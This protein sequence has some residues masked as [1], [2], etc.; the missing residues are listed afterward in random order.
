[1]ANV[2]YGCTLP[3]LTTGDK[4]TAV[5]DQCGDNITSAVG[6]A[7]FGETAGKN[8]TDGYD[9]TFIGGHSGYYTTSAHNL[10]GVGTGA[11]YKNET[12]INLTASGVNALRNNT[13]G[14][15]N[16][17]SGYLASYNLTTAYQTSS[18]GQAALRNNNGNNTSGFGVEAG[19]NATTSYNSSFF[20]VISGSNVTTQNNVTCLGYNTQVT[21]SNQ[22]QL[23]D[24]YTTS[25]AYGAV[26]NR[27]DARDKTDIRDCSIG[28]DFIM[29]LRPVDYKWNYRDAYVDPVVTHEEIEEEVPVLVKDANGK[30]RYEK[31]KVKKAVPVTKMVK[32]DNDGSR[33]RK[34]YHH[35]LIA[36]EVM[37][38]GY[39]FGGL[40]DH[41]LN[42]GD[43][44]LTI[45][46][47]ELIAPMIK[48]MQEMKEEIDIL[49]SR[50]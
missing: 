23:G 35:G 16:T 37:Q 18:Y 48:A 8:I 27:S 33:S 46:Y 43:D 26:Q 19:L 32:R 9:I 17:A 21:G 28:L 13:T 7:I 6:I 42:G 20:G 24:S 34:R 44:V 14:F 49:R 5:G 50:L 30:R 11:L 38:T 22:L 29:K 25:Y 2:I 31:K 45:G 1:M 3:S 47:E 10:T 41:S 40:Q 36:Q 39:D 15:S 4:I 12:G